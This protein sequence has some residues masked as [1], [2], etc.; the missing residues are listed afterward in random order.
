MAMAVDQRQHAQYSGLPLDHT[1]RY[2]APQFTNPWVSA[3]TSSS[4][5][6]TALAP[7]TNNEQVSR[8][9]SMSMPYAGVPVSAPS[10]G[11]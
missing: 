6:S 4:M 3:A 5:Y 11:P 7:S 2:A 9:S 1:M 8:S 10:L